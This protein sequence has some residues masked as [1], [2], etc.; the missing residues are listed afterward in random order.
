VSGTLGPGVGKGLGTAP[1]EAQAPVIMARAIA[2][3]SSSSRSALQ[4]IS[5]PCYRT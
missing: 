1:V 4:I 2:Q 3:K 5:G